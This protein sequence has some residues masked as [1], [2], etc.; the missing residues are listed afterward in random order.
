MQ[1]KHYDADHLAFADAVRTF[2]GKELLPDYPT[3]ERA[4]LAPRDIFTAAGA[5]GFLG[6]QIPE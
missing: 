2:I 1:R 5:N 4:G 3:W 6:I